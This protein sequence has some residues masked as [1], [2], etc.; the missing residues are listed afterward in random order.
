MSLKPLLLR[1]GDFNNIIF[2]FVCKIRGVALSPKSNY[3]HY[4]VCDVA[5]GCQTYFLKIGS[6]QK[7][8]RGKLR[9][10]GEIFIAFL[11]ATRYIFNF[12]RVILNS[13]RANFFNCP[14]C[15]RNFRS[16]QLPGFVRAIARIVIY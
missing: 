10:E 9:T 6:L 15:V 3:G 1:P 11:D 7:A 2:G 8:K 4:I 13:R 16:G 14:F 12:S 5:N